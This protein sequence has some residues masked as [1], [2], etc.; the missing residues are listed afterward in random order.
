MCGFGGIINSS[1]KRHSADLSTIAEKVNFRGPDN[2][3]VVVYD[4]DFNAV[5]EGS[6][7]I[8]F[9]RLAI[10]DL[11]ERA[12]QPFEDEDSLLVFNGEI[13]NYCDLRQL[14]QNEGV[15][16]HTSSDT[17][18]LFYLLK[19][20]GKDAISK[21]NGMFSFCF[22]NKKQDSFLMARDRLGIK[23]LYYKQSQSGFVF[24]SELKSIAL[25]SPESNTISSRAIEA[26]LALQY[27]PTPLS[28]Y[29]EVKKLEPGHYIEAPISD[30]SHRFVESKQYWDAYRTKQT[31]GELDLTALHRLLECSI[32]LHLQADVPV[33]LFLSS[34]VDSS[35]LAAV[36]NTPKFKDRNFN[37]FTVAYDEPDFNDESESA[38]TYLNGFNNKNFIHNRL[39]VHQRDIIMSSRSM[40]SY[41]DEP[42]GDSAF[43]LNYAI[44]VA[45]RKHV[46]VALSG[47]GADELFWGYSRYEQWRRLTGKSKVF[48]FLSNVYPVLKPFDFLKRQGAYRNRLEKDP[49]IVYS[50][51]VRSSYV[52]LEFSFQTEKQLWAS[53]SLKNI[54]TRASLP[55]LFDIKTYLPDCMNY[56]VDRSS[57]AASLEVRVPYMENAMIDFA[58][59]TPL[60][61]NSNKAFSQKALL[62]QLLLK[63]APHYTN[64]TVKKG[65]NFPLQKWLKEH[66]REDIYSVISD[67]T[68][69]TLGIEKAPI[70]KMLDAFYKGKNNA[71]TDV[72]YLYNLALWYHHNHG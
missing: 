35:L 21:L 1:I 38:E 58:L 43:L 31:G 16:F 20:Y 22:I 29:N 42:F 46:K 56:K 72:W 30:L 3:R 59:Q 70:R 49:F 54:S 2:T 39:L 60:C 51:L 26:Y 25:L 27:I 14:L 53:K 50:N 55:S 23:P 8:F 63:L 41:V 12:N 6:V 67:T 15:R 69:D 57:M 11:G 4:S 7:G 62:K 44:S 71:S 19:C 40:Y 32:N 64:S 61:L 48:N 45:A 10:I 9:N 17:E 28:I 5:E 34:G 47:D 18:V 66:W 52:G 33:G 13:Y 65:F 24:A 36:L 68:L 37:F